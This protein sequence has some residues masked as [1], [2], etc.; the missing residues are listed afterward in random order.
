MCSDDGFEPYREGARRLQLAKLEKGLGERALSSVFGEVVIT[1]M[2][3]RLGVDGRAEIAGE[4]VKGE[5]GVVFVLRGCADHE[6]F[7]WR[8][9]I[10][11]TEG[12]TKSRSRQDCV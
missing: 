10:P 6:V 5:S 9:C 2:P 4:S 1:K 12:Y 7:V 3:K 8:H 11:D